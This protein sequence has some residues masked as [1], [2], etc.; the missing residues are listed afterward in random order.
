MF[1]LLVALSLL[2]IGIALG[3]I[4]S[5]PPGPINLLIANHYISNKK[6]A[7][8][9]FIAGIILADDI[10]A[11]LAFKGYE[12]FLEGNTIGAWVSLMGGVLVIV[13]GAIGI[14]AAFKSVKN[15]QGS[16]IE[17]PKPM[18]NAWADFFKGVALCGLNP[19]LLFF[20]VSV[21][22][23]P[24]GLIAD[25]FGEPVELNILFFSVLLIGITFGEI[26]WFAFFIKIL[27]YGAKKFGDNILFY[28]RVILSGILV[29]LGVYLL[30]FE[31][32]LKL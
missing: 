19:G 18:G 16:V 29:L 26:F 31:G 1:V 20:W 3:F 17:L 11:F 6:L 30:I 23:L 15:A 21:T 12:T 22:S 28:L 5:I 32:A 25:I 8:I 13:F 7:I 14:F 4:A 27:T 2:I 10:L 24:Q 9:P